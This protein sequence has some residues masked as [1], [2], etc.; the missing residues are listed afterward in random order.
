MLNLYRRG[1]LRS[2]SKSIGSIG[3]GHRF[4]GNMTNGKYL[5]S[6]GMITITIIVNGNYY[7]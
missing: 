3:S 1:L 7:G 4:S 2:P 5:L 6:M